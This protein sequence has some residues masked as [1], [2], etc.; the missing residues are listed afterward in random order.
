MAGLVI[1]TLF[2]LLLSACGPS[3]KELLPSSSSLAFRWW[4]PA[5]DPAAKSGRRAVSP[6]EIDPSMDDYAALY[7]KYLGN[8]VTSITP[9]RVHLA[10]GNLMLF[11]DASNVSLQI[12]DQ[13]LYRI[14]GHYPPGVVPYYCIDFVNGTTT[15]F[16]NQPVPAGSY[17]S[18]ELDWRPYVDETQNPYLDPSTDVS[19]FPG[20]VIEVQLPGFSSNTWFSEWLSSHYFPSNPID[21]PDWA[22][23]DS[24]P[25]ETY[26]LN[27]W[28]LDLMNI[29]KQTN[30]YKSGGLP[31][32]SS[33]I[34]YPSYWFKQGWKYK[35]FLPGYAGYPTY[36]EL[37]ELGSYY[38]ESNEA[39]LTDQWGC[40][41]YCPTFALPFSGITVPPNTKS[42]IVHVNLDTT[43]LIEI[44]DNGTPGDTS[45]DIA[46]LAKDL[47]YRFSVS[48]EL[49]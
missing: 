8:R 22:P 26:R 25:A 27:T 39:G 1:A 31:E 12:K 6:S 49:Q 4:N 15:L 5:S 20:T 3:P 46:V 34:G 14:N 45:D 44:Y 41:I 32:I 35:A 18:L 40:S 21:V 19:Q 47:P 2:A 28:Q 16:P 13:G 36:S 30:A 11:D 42:V 17:N 10:M 38:P 7:D 48:F 23:L 9:T 43:G 29:Y 24:L 37:S 33:K